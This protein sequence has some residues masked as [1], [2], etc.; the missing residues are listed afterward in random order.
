MIALMVAVARTLVGRPSSRE[1]SAITTPTATATKG[2]ETMIK[3]EPV[4]F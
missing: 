3:N 4:T 2:G 1:R